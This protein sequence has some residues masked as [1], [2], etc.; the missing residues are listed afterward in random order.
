MTAGVP[1]IA[2]LRWPPAAE[3]RQRLQACFSNLRRRQIHSQFGL[4]AVTWSDYGYRVTCPDQLREASGQF[5]AIRTEVND[6][7]KFTKIR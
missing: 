2:M 1:V 6:F 3:T 5:K 7:T 4:S